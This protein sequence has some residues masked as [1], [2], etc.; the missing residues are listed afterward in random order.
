MQPHQTTDI[1]LEFLRYTQNGAVWKSTRIVYSISYRQRR[2]TPQSWIEMILFCLAV[3]RV[4]SGD[5]TRRTLTSSTLLSS[6]HKSHI[7]T[8]RK[9]IVKWNSILSWRALSLVLSRSQACMFGLCCASGVV[10]F[11]AV[12]AC[13]VQ[14]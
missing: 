4:L 8:Q 6:R 12:I 7:N 9:H 11:S 2:V 14:N 1:A 3:F 10:L 13:L 5:M